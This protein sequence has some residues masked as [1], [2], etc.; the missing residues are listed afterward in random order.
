MGSRTSGALPHPPIFVMKTE[1]PTDKIKIKQWNLLWKFFSD[2]EN[3]FV[4]K[5]EGQYDM[6]YVH[7][8][9]LCGNRM[10]RDAIK[11]YISGSLFSLYSP[12]SDTESYQDKFD[13]MEI[14]D[15]DKIEWNDPLSKIKFS[16]RTDKGLFLKIRYISNKNRKKYA[17]IKILNNSS[18]HNLKKLM[19]TI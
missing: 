15:A 7:D 12:K 16:T 2:L 6:S 10:P 3:E 5:F 9:E 4:I 1:T 11:L 17:Y 13:Y 19:K 18:M 8:V 14:P